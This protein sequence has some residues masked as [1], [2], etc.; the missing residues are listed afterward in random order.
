[1]PIKKSFECHSLRHRHL[2]A[3]NQTPSRS[4]LLST[5]D[6]NDDNHDNEVDTDDFNWVW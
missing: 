6:Y 1:M 2:K 4:E 5:T 3:T